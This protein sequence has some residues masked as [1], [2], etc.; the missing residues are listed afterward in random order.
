M[1]LPDP[2]QESGETVLKFSLL[3]AG[4]GGH[5]ASACWA[6]GGHHQ[7]PGPLQAG[8]QPGGGGPGG[9]APGLRQQGQA[10]QEGQEAAQDRGLLDSVSADLI[11]GCLSLLAEALKMWGCRSKCFAL[12]FSAV[13]PSIINSAARASIVIG[14]SYGVR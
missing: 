10:P 6:G 8:S 11:R 3:V 4:A 13:W 1:D 7:V 9:Q 2:V 14:M 12:F 5:C